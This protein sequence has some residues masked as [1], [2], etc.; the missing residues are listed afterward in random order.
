MAVCKKHGQI[1]EENKMIYRFTI[2][3]DYDPQ[4]YKDRLTLE[5]AK[6][7]FIDDIACNNF[8]IEDE[9]IGG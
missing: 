9:T 5:D 2:T 6:E 1:L 3:K 8:R 4:D 7:Q